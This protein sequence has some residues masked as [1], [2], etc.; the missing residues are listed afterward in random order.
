VLFAA[1]ENE[2][3]NRQLLGKALDQSRK[4]M[5]VSTWWEDS[6]GFLHF[7]SLSA[8]QKGFHAVAPSNT[9]IQTI[10]SNSGLKLLSER[11]HIL[12]HQAGRIN[13]K[14]IDNADGTATVGDMLE[15]SPKYVAETLV[16]V[17]DLG[18]ALL[19][20]SPSLL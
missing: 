10:L 17:R 4:K 15:P 1:A 12:V 9:A 11:R 20:E 18:I 5:A 19:A 16:M 14:Y 3:A 13:Q 8:I 6:K 2:P 7:N